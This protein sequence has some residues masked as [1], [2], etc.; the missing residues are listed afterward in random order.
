MVYRVTETR[1]STHT[2]KPSKWV[3]VYFHKQASDAHWARCWRRIGS[4]T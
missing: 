2:Q 4:W 1:L 3:S